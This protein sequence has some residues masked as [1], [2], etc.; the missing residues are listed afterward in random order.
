MN[1]KGKN[2]RNKQRWEKGE[3]KAPDKAILSLFSPFLSFLSFP[4]SLIFFPRLFSFH[5]FFAYF[6]WS[7]CH[8]T[9]KIKATLLSLLSPLSFPL[10]SQLRTFSRLFS[11]TFPCLLF[12]SLTVEI[13]TMYSLFF[14]LFFLFFLSLSLYLSTV[15]LLFSTFFLLLSLVSLSLSALS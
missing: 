4:V 9:F 7:G 11:P 5:F 6:P 14:L 10:F 12:L 15:S 13:K 3:E 8:L 2:E 1:R